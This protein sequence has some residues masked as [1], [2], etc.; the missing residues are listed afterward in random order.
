MSNQKRTMTKALGNALLFEA[1]ALAVSALAWVLGQPAWALLLFVASHLPGS[2]LMFPVLVAAS[3]L[4]DVYQKGGGVWSSCLPIPGVGLVVA[5]QVPFLIA[6][7]HWH[8]MDGGGQVQ[9]SH[10]FRSL[11][12]LATA[13]F[14]AF[15]VA[16]ACLELTPIR[17]SGNCVP[18]MPGQ[19]Y[20]QPSWELG[21]GLGCSVVPFGT[22]RSDHYSTITFEWWG[23]FEYQSPWRFAMLGLYT[24]I[25]AVPGI[26]IVARLRG[27][28]RSM[29]LAKKMSSS[30][31]SHVIERNIDD[32][33]R[34]AQG[35]VSS[36]YRITDTLS[37]L[38]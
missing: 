6:F 31:S 3:A 37:L 16:V 23:L 34:K 22:L 24:A 8:M 21:R 27:H 9:W 30:L 11:R 28:G 7:F 32:D 4:F 18:L 36:L 25:G 17:I 1:A 2:L 26:W 13:S 12:I 19:P 33:N 5:V 35:H 20:P 29:G 38:L 15:L 10:A 14:V